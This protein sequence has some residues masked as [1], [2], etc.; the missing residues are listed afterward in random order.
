MLRGAEALA[1]AERESE[2]MGLLDQPLRAEG[3]PFRGSTT[4]ML[5]RRWW[6]DD[7]ALQVGLH[8]VGVEGV[9]VIGGL[10]AANTW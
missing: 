7:A 9:G 5:V 4:R 8:F 3:S 6:A 10:A 2:R 1:E